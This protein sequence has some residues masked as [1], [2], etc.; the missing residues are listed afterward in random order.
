[1]Q[2]YR[3]IARREWSSKQ[4]THL[5]S[6]FRT[7]IS[8]SV[9][10]RIAAIQVASRRRLVLPPVVRSAPVK[11]T[12]CGMTQRS[13]L[14]KSLTM[15]RQRSISSFQNFLLILFLVIEVSLSLRLTNVDTLH[16]TGKFWFL[17]SS[18]TTTGQDLETSRYQRQSIHHET[19]LLLQ[20]NKLPSR[21][22]NYK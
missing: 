16:T 18:A 1:M 5:V 12:N 17:P 4:R 22:W 2:N 19:I 13:L 3:R 7:G 8:S 10:F 9:A 14:R 15:F 6:S 21:I 20:T 11:C